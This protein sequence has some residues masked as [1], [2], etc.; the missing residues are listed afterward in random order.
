MA[1][2]SRLAFAV[3]ALGVST[4]AGAELPSQAKSAKPPE[5]AQPVRKCNIGG[6]TGVVAADGVCV[7]LSGSVSA[8]FSAGQIK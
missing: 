1:R 7:R 2:V 8:G 5:H 6:V 4:A 3:L